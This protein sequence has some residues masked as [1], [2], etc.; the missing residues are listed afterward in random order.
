ME[1]LGNE[2]FRGVIDAAPEGIVVCAA[3]GA[4]NPVVYANAAFERLTG[5]SV[6]ELLGTDLRRLQ[7]TDREQEGRARL[8][9]ALSQGAGTRALLR[10]Y[11]K[12]GAQFWNEIFLEPVRAAGGSVTHFVAFHRDV[13]ERERNAG[14]R[15]ATGLPAWMRQDRLT[16]LHAR[17]YFEELLRHDWQVA[18]REERLLTVMLFGID[19]LDHYVERFGRQ[20]GD[21]CIRRLAGVVN[22]CFRRGSDVVARWEGGAL[23][24][25]VRSTAPGA[26]EGFAHTITQR[27]LEQCIHFPRPP[28]GKYVTVSVGVASLMPTVKQQPEALLRGA[29][30]ALKRA[31]DGAGGRV[32]LAG[33]KDFAPS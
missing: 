30:R 13:G 7:G 25:L 16:S 33:S 23:V 28:A 26:L 17:A 6:D 3:N 8:R 18:K 9:Q 27:V 32:V 22:A 5:F 11:R 2:V 14:A 1:E 19:A 15:E 31:Q 10:N 21:T 29:E 20:A 12:D 4:D 24:A